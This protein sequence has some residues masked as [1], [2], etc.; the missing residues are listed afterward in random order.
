M[1]YNVDLHPTDTWMEMEKLV[2]LGLVKDIGVS[3]FNSVQIQDIIEKGTIKP[4]V[5]QVECHPYMQQN[6]LIEFCKYHDILVTAYSPLGTPTRPWASSDEE[7]LLD[8]SN[9]TEIANLHSKTPAQIVLRWQ[10]ERGVVVV[11][12]SVNESRIHENFNIFDFN[13]KETE[14]DELKK[15][16]KGRFG[17]LLAVKTKGGLFWDTDHPHFPFANSF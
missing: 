10:I 7:K 5:N 3:N 14:V 16:D 1:K 4:V 6:K 13:L 8:N 11:P 17:R 12:K 2:E 15:F 9:L